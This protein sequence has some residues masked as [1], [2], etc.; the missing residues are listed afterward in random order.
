ME[1][2]LQ[3]IKRIND[4]KKQQKSRLEGRLES[5]NEK[6]KEFDCSSIEDLE[7]LIE[8]KEKEVELNKVS[9]EEKI[10]ELE[11]YVN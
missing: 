7:K 3:E 6:L 9:L 4:E 11:D 10:K 5:L 2:R 1:D 8:E